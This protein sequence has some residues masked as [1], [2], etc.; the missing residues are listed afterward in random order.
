MYLCVA[1]I[2]GDSDDT[3]YDKPFQV[4]IDGP[5][6]IPPISSTTSHDRR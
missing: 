6:W 4:V 3:W 1:N 5:F 2:M